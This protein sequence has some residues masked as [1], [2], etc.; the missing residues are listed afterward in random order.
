MNVVLTFYSNYAAITNSNP[1]QASGS[2]DLDP[3]G[4]QLQ[5]S[6]NIS[7]MKIWRGPFNV[8]CTTSREPQSVMQ[9]MVRALDVNRV[10]YKKIG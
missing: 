2:I 8:N 1:Y 3:Y 7:G 4:D 10:S 9:E 5:S 6:P